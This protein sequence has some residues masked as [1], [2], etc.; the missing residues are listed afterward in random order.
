MGLA[1][2]HEV[3]PKMLDLVRRITRCEQGATAVEYGLIISLVVVAL[4]AAMGNLAG[5]TT[6]M[7]NH[8]SNQ[9]V[10]NTKDKG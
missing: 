10:E 7:W 2:S 8:V 4:I 3:G 9:I 6:N 1:T 5:S